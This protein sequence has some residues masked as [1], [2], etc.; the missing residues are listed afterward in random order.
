M[1]NNEESEQVSPDIS[2]KKRLRIKQV[3]T[4]NSRNKT[5][6]ILPPIINTQRHHRSTTSVQAYD[7]VKVNKRSGLVQLATIEPNLAKTLSQP[8][9]TVPGKNDAKQ[10]LTPK[11]RSSQGLDRYGGTFSQ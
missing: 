3:R 2:A 6:T 10:L 1:Q 8:T 7:K 5:N 4:L 9:L 11:N